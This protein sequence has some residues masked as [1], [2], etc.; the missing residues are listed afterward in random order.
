MAFLC[1]VFYLFWF[2]L[3]FIS[4]AEQ[5]KTQLF[6]SKCLKLYLVQVYEKAKLMLSKHALRALQHSWNMWMLQHSMTL[7]FLRAGG[8]SVT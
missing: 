6:I 7:P 8:F 1:V 4:Y 5:I 2:C 3:V